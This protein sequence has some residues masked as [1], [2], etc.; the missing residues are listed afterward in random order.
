[1]FY[2]NF[3]FFK[4]VQKCYILLSQ[5]HENIFLKMFFFKH[6]KYILPKTKLIALSYNFLKIIYFLIKALGTSPKT[7]SL[8]YISILKISFKINKLFFLKKFSSISLSYKGSQLNKKKIFCKKK[9]LYLYNFF[10]IKSFFFWS[11]PINWYYH[12]I[13]NKIYLILLTSKGSYIFKPLV[14]GIYIV[15]KYLCAT[16]YWLL[17]IPIPLGF[18]SAIQ[19]FWYSYYYYWLYLNKFLFAT[20]AGTFIKFLFF[21]NQKEVFYIQ[22]PSLKIIVIPLKGYIFVGRNSNIFLNKIIRGGFFSNYISW[23]KQSYSTRGVSMN[24]VDHPNGGR[25]RVKNPLKTPW[26]YIAKKGK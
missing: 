12:F 26:G 6:I 9:K 24:P 14:W 21:D 18:S 16:I 15:T 23:K 7:R 22:L 8:C 13:T 11:L 2:K 20:S 1:M 3:V 25:T 4:K 10:F 19:Y 5:I 17:E